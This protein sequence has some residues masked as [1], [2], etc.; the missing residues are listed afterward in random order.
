MAR[1]SNPDSA[2]SQFFI[3]FE[4]APHLNGQ[5]TAWGKV[6]SGMEYV[7]AIKKGDQYDNGSVEDPDKMISVK[8]A[9]DVVGK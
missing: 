8:V 4:A 7:D 1:S 9:A 5:Y 6:I 3:V 2:D